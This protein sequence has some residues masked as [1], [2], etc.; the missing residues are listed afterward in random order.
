MWQ[1]LIEE[2]KELAKEKIANS[3]TWQSAAW[4][5]A[6]WN[7]ANPSITAKKQE[8]NVLKNILEENHG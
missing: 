5:S 4:Q 8:Y 7:S 6:S 3:S 2:R 1:K